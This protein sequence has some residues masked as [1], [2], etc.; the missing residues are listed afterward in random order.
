MSKRNTFV[1]FRCQ[2]RKELGE[3][4]DEDSKEESYCFSCITKM[5]LYVLQGEKE[6]MFKLCNNREEFVQKMNEI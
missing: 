3:S 4:D 5:A 6:E 1:C 2:E